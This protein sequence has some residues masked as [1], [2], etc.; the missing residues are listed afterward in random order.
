MADDINIDNLVKQYKE[1]KKISLS[2]TS[3]SSINQAEEK[4]VD[5]L[6][7]QSDINTRSNLTTYFLIG[8]FL[9]LILA[10]V[11]VLWYN[12]LS[13][14]WLLTLKYSGVEISDGFIKPLELESVLSLIINSFGTSLGF[15]IGY[16]FKDKTS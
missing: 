11:F 5:A 16:Y 4:L 2:S 8:L 13:M 9:L 1:T 7:K 6:K 3:Q 15:I 12:H 14:Q 10:G